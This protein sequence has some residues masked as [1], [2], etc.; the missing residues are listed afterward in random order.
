M[1]EEPLLIRPGV[2]WWQYGPLNVLLTS[3]PTKE[4]EYPLPL[5]ASGRVAAL[6]AT[7]AFL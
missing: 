3:L 7:C 4:K 2:P 5:R 6:D 1:K